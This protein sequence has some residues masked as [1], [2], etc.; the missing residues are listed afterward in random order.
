M[1]KLQCL[2]LG[3]IM[4]QLLSRGSRMTELQRLSL[5]LIMGQLLPR[6]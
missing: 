4:G 3:F 1:T 5:G 2:S 6:G